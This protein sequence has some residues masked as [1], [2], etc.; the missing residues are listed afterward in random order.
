VEYQKVAGKL[1]IDK[2]SVSQ[3]YLKTCFIVGIQH[4]TGVLNYIGTQIN[5]QYDKITFCNFSIIETI[6]DKLKT[7]VRLNT[8]NTGVSPTSYLN[9]VPGL[10]ACSFMVKN[11]GFN[12][13]RFRL[14]LNLFF[15]NPLFISNSGYYTKL[16]KPATEFH[17]AIQMI[18]RY[19]KILVTS[20]L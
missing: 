13:K 7:F 20:N 5:T 10:L 14:H 4:I 17:R 18:C 1:L 6:N 2:G 15:F 3:N 11:Q 12:T 19:Y 16:H 9:R 8:P